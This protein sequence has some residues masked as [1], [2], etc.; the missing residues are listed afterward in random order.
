MI[1]RIKEIENYIKVHGIAEYCIE[2]RQSHSI[3]NITV[4][5][6]QD[7]IRCQ[8]VVFTDQDGYEKMQ[9]QFNMTKELL[10]TTMK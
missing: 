2:A 3:T 8:C 1:N 7:Y 4:H 10:K 5:W 9:S 6:V